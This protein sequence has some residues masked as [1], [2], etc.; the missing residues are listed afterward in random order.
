[1]S[2]MIVGYTRGGGHAGMFARGKYC[3]NDGA[4][5]NHL[6]IFIYC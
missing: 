5:R 4:V 6:G 1:M 2:N 3:E